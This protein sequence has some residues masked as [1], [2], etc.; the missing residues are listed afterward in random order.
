VVK[1]FFGWAF[2][3]DLISAD[4]TAKM[5]SLPYVHNQVFPLSQEEMARILKA[6]S[7]C[8]FSP[9]VAFRVKTF[10]LLQRWSGLAC[11]DAATLAR[12]RLLPDNNLTRVKRKKTG[13]GVFVPL[14]PTVADALRALQND[15]P[16]YFF[17]N[18]KRMARESVVAMFGDYLRTVF[19]TAK[20]P[21]GREEMLSHRFRHTF[22]VEMLLAGVGLDEVSVLLGHKT[23]R[24]SERYYSAWVKARQV[25]LE[26]NVK[27]A[28]RS[29][30]LPEPV[31]APAPACV[32]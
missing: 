6:T 25:R 24:T 27:D 12:D 13:T 28:W 10:I 7:E 18:P 20:V 17:W 31:V 29:M 21:H 9:E 23:L 1:T 3:T 16:D 11:M 26:L 2:A 22:A 5:K 15:H 8:G 19:D 4:P 32:Q 30:V 14:P